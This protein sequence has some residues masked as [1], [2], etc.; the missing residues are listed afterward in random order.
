M[1]GLLGLSLLPLLAAGSPVVIDTIHKDAAPVI[2][3]SN[4]KDIPNSYMV[5]FKKHVTERDA[6]AHHTWVQDVH[7]STEI[8]KQELRKRSLTSFDDDTIFEGLRHTYNIPGGLLGYAGHFDEDVIELV[9]RHPDVSSPIFPCGPIFQV[10]LFEAF[11]INSRVLTV[12]PYLGIF[13]IALF[14]PYPSLP[15]PESKLTCLLRSITSN[16]T[17]RSILSKT[18]L[19]W[20]RTLHG[21]WP[22]SLTVM[23]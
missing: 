18:A 3:S 20:K 23:L 10:E 11:I 7:L 21:V 5:I 22:V 9:R 2:S 6:S 12:H 16:V 15:C 8:R 1:K 4:A 19:N 13:C 14:G 17:P